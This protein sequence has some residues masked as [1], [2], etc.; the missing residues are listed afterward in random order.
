MS[1]SC[2]RVLSTCVQRWLN[3]RVEFHWPRARAVS[4]L[5]EPSEA[6]RSHLAP[7]RAAD[8]PDEAQSNCLWAPAQ[9]GAHLDSSILLGPDFLGPNCRPCVECS[10]RGA[11]ML[12][13]VG[14]RQ[15]ALAVRPN[16][17]LTNTNLCRRAESGPKAQIAAHWTGQQT[18]CCL[19]M[20][21]KASA[22]RCAEIYGRQSQKTL[23][24]HTAQP[25]SA[26]LSSAQHNKTQ[27]NTTRHDTKSMQI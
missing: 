6:T 21:A 23:I 14:P 1:D 16:S 24:E 7:S 8:K 3:R 15:L 27:H 20:A 4:S 17:A 5:L 25:S 18:R 11:H 10:H 26:Q 12:S 22:P 13:L 19:S 9:I 2:L